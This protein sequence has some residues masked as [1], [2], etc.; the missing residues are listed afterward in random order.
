MKQSSPPLSAISCVLLAGVLVAC[1]PSA[2]QIAQATAGAETSTA[3]AWTPTPSATFTFTPTA[4]ATPTST[5]TPSPTRTA[6]PTSTDTPVPTATVT[7]TNTPRPLPTFT[8][9]VPPQA[10]VFPQTVIHGWDPNDFRNELNELV[11]FNTDF[12]AYFQRV[13]EQKEQ[14]QCYTFYNYRNEM[15]ASQAAYEN[16]PPVWY[17]IYYEYRVLVHEAFANVQPITAVCDAGGGTVSDE[18]DLII[19]QGLASIIDRAQALVL[20]AAAIP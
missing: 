17:A 6:T 14:G 4:T 5:D 1:V 9:T 12:R 8:A 11:K 3:A 20:R 16:V 18:Q 7:V 15:L 2:E 10:P 19:L 13:V